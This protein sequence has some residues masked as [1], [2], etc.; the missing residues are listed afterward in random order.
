MSITRRALAACSAGAATA[1]ALGAT[2]VA[3][4]S[5]S[6]TRMDPQVAC[7]KKVGH[8]HKAH[9]APRDRRA[10][11][12]ATQGHDHDRQRCAWLGFGETPARVTSATTARFV[13]SSVVSGDENVLGGRHLRFDEWRD[14][15]CRL[16]GDVVVP[17]GEREATVVLAGL[18]PGRHTF[19]VRATAPVVHGET[20]DEA[21]D[22]VAEARYVWTIVGPV[23]VEPL[24]A[25]F[26]RIEGLVGDAP[27][28]LD[29]STSVAGARA[30]GGR[31]ATAPVAVPTPVVVTDEAS[32]STPVPPGAGIGRPDVAPT[33]TTAPD[34]DD[35]A[36][37]RPAGGAQAAVGHEPERPVDGGGSPDRGG[38]EPVVPDGGDDTDPL[39]P[40]GDAG[41]TPSAPPEAEREEVADDHEAVAPPA[42]DE[43]EPVFVFGAME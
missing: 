20:G 1:L 31:D 40:A 7:V 13:M 18:A 3:N 23:S 12:G 35:A 4:P 42:P 14:H 36:P 30:D 29:P 33:A 24:V 5:V 26:R 10:A 21:N 38:E 2:A 17:C 15:E 41:E 27:A 37:P 25:A 34:R 16:D 11:V 19:S 8:E 39:P 6:P 32:S 28:P 9:V 43:A 22:H